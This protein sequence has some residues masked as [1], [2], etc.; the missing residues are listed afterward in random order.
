MA[1]RTSTSRFVTE[2]D[3][4]DVTVRDQANGEVLVV[5]RIDRGQ[6]GGMPPAVVVETGVS[7]VAYQDERLVAEVGFAFMLA[8]RKMAER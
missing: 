1:E 2:Q 8:A 6:V 3:A 5:L 4:R 7:G